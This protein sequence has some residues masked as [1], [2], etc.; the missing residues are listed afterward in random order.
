M[1][2]PGLHPL[3][4]NRPRRFFEIDLR[5]T[6]PKDIAGS[7]SGENQKL[8]RQSDEFTRTTLLKIPHELRNRLVMHCFEVASPIRRPW[9]TGTYANGGISPC[10]VAGNGGPLKDSANALPDAPCCFVLREPDRRQD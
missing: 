2:A 5:P 8:Q 4:G 10:A 1:F 6:R 9:Q 7:G 3:G